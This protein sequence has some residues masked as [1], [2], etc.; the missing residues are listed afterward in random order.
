MTKNLKEYLLDMVYPRTCP[1]CSGIPPRGEYVCEDCRVKLPYI[2][3]PRCMKCSKPILEK[4][5]EYCYDCMKKKHSYVSG[6]AVWV[7]DDVMRESIARYKYKGSL[8]YAEFYGKEIAD[9]HGKWIK[10]HGDILVP[11]PL[12]KRKQRIRGYNQA[13]VLAKIIGEKLQIPVRSKGLYRSRD[14]LPQKELNDAERLKNLAKAFEAD[15]EQFSPA[16]KV[17][18]VDD[19]YTT[20]S[21]IEACTKALQKAGVREIYFISICI[22]KGF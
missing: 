20:G 13:E 1:V 5:E 22:G 19:I 7:Y 16:E 15:K 9:C 12:H 4:E 3:G 14:T 2:K 11:V 6:R 21:T 10:V 18:L 17:M 8:E